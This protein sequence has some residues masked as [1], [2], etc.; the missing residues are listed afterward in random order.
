MKR[1]IIVSIALLLATAAAHHAVAQPHPGAAE[2]RQHI[3]AAEQ[4]LNLSDAQKASWEAALSDLE[5]TTMAV[6][7]K[8]RT[9]Q[10]QLNEALSA[11]SPDA[12]TVGNLAIQ[13]HAAMDQMKAAH[14][15]LITKLGSYLTPDQKA[16]F[17]AYVAA[18]TAQHREPG[19]PPMH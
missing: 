5:S 19:P 15:S 11:A 17:D 2:M 6:M 7:A 10:K 13:A 14:E 16:K 3:T 8:A 12:C 4:Y 1:A 18:A 9:S